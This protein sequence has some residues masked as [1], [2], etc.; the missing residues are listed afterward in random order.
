MMEPL[1]P[2]LKPAKAGEEWADRWGPE[3]RS[4]FESSRPPTEANAASTA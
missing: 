3:Q 2:L 4:A 1:R